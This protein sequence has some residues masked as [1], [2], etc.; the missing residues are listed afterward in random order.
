MFNIVIP[1]YKRNK[2]ILDKVL[3]KVIFYHKLNEKYNIYIFI[4]KEEYEDYKYLEQYKNIKLVLGYKGL[5]HQRDYI[6][7]YFE[8]DTK[9]LILDDDIIKINIFNYTTL[10]SAILDTFE[11]ML[12]NNL[13]ICGVNP[14]SNFY[15]NECTLKKGFYFCVGCCY[16]EINNKHPLLYYKNNY[17]FLCLEDEKEDYIRTINHYQ[18]NALV[19]RN[20]KITFVHKFGYTIGGMNNDLS[21]EDKKLRQYV[22][23]LSINLINGKYPNFTKIKNKKY[24]PELRIFNQ[25]FYKKYITKKTNA[26]LATYINK[27]ET[28][29]TLCKHKN[30][31]LYDVETKQLIGIILRNVINKK[32][33]TDEWFKKIDNWTKYKNENRGDIAG[34]I[35]IDK[36]PNYLKNEYNNN[37]DKLNK[38]GSRVMLEKGYQFSNSINCITLGYYTK[39]KLSQ[40]DNKYG[41]WIQDNFN[42]IL[43]QLNNIYKH[44][45]LDKFEDT[46]PQKKYLNSYFSS[47]TINKGLR[48]AVH[49]DKNNK[50]YFALLMVLSNPKYGGFDGAEVLLPDYKLD[51]NIN[52]SKDVFIFDSKNVKHCNNEFN[53]YCKKDSRLSCVFFSK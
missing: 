41:E 3:N 10:E 29:N 16:F 35:D 19:G 48:S 11:Y 25:V 50:H 37:Q 7:D 23:N 14:T 8:N 22:N 34:K 42:N 33:F 53:K 32:L 17:S 46:I 52:P 26:D 2:I 45:Y 44:I 21:I 27:D 4:I 49:T 12:N 15:F 40:Y 30:F 5:I 18:Y 24:G 6:R 38:T 20:D 36:L 9:L 51:I 13:Y 39:N 28:F 47:I 31:L 43:E 1:S